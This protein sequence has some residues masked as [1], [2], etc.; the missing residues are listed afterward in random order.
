MR[1]TVKNCSFLRANRVKSKSAIHPS[2]VRNPNFQSPPQLSQSP[3]PMPALRTQKKEMLHALN[4]MIAQSD[5]RQSRNTMDPCSTASPQKR[6]FVRCALPTVAR[7]L[8][9]CS[10]LSV[11]LFVPEFSPSPLYRWWQFFV[12]VLHG[13]SSS[14]NS[15]IVKKKTPQQMS[16][17]TRKHKQEVASTADYIIKAAQHPKLKTIL[18]TCSVQ[19]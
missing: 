7:W 1:R 9:A 8:L 14:F 3:K 10:P 18:S 4:A 19:Q 17:N 11:T 2:K 16:K 13:P 6:F 12:D 5:R 15:S